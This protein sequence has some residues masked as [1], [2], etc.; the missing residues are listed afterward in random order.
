MP[1]IS[2]ATYPKIRSAPEFQLTMLPFASQADD[3][4]LGRFDNGGQPI[5]RLLRLPALVSRQP[6]LDGA[7]YRQ[8]QTHGA[9]FEH[10]IRGAHFDAF[11]RDVFAHRAG[12]QN[13]GNLLVLLAQQTKGLGSRPLEQIVIGQHDIVPF[14]TQGPEELV[15]FRDDIHR[16]LVAGL[17]QLPSQKSY[18]LRIVLYVEYGQSYACLLRHPL[19]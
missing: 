2:E 8:R 11:H 13:E 10:I 1:W 5:A 12:H 16:G 17:F 14:G 18:V 15:W 9:V 6:F 4:I 3:G 19:R 7:L